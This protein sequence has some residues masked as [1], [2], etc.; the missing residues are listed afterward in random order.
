MPGPLE[1]IRILDLTWVLS[2]P[3]ASMVLSDLGAEV[4]KVERPPFGD[5]ARTNGPFINGE[6]CYFFS[7]NRGKQSIA[8][9]LGRQAGRDLFLRLVDEADVVME[10]F[11]PGVMDR[12]GL[13]YEAL[14]RRN[15]RLVYAAVSGF[16][17]TGP[18]R[19]R[20]ALDVI[21]QGMGGIMSITGQPGGPPIRPGASYGD[22]VAGLFA[23]VGVLAAL[24]ERTRSGLGQL[25]DVSMLDCQI[26][27]LENAFM[28][29]FATG[30]VPGP[31]GTRHPTSTPFQAFETKDGH[32][33]IAL[34][35]N[36]ESQWE[37]LC[38]LIGCPELI[39]DPRFTTSALRTEHH[40]ALEPI[41]AAAL[42]QRTTAEWLAEFGPLDLPCG[43][44]NTIAEAA[45]DPQVTAR[46]MLVD[47]DHPVIGPLKLANT[48]VRLSRTPGA[49]RGP[50]PAVGEHTETALET[51][52]GLDPDEI[53]S[54]HRDGA[55]P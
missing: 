32:I 14:R 46:E 55:I 27:A 3:Y 49:I 36:V 41:L 21:V 35:W 26:A 13:G 43:P 5:I 22:I 31:L 15:P 40:A 28:R 1:G 18:Y 9:D 48:P 45:A 7:I 25:V 4:V 33:V 38:G 34:S 42:R 54:L 8:I 2:G 44:V 17:Q 39:D 51:W 6:S 30:Q 10:N 20:P 50:S 47:V 19:E 53:V 16:G 52:L 23:A 37:V 29:Y 12:L 11:T 24:Q